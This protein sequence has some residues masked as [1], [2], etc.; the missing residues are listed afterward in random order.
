MGNTIQPRAID[1]I[2]LR[3]DRYGAGGMGRSI[4]SADTARITV[5]LRAGV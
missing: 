5:E 1:H 3:T 2:V 4:N